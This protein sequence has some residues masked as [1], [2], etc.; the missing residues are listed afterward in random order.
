MVVFPDRT[1]AAGPDS[2]GRDRGPLEL[3]VVGALSRRSPTRA[4]GRARARADRRAG[5]DREPAARADAAVGAARSTPGA[6]ERSRAGSSRSF[7]CRSCGAGR[8]HVG[9]PLGP[10][11]V[12]RMLRGSRSP[13]ADAADARPMLAACRRRGARRVRARRRAAA[14]RRGD[15]RLGAA[16]HDLLALAHP[17]LGGPGIAARQ[18]P[19]A[20]AA[21]ELA[22][23]G[24]PTSA[25]EAVNRHSLLARLPEIVRVD[26]TVQFWLGQPDLRGRGRRPRGSWRCRRCGGCGSKRPA[27]AGCARSGSRPSAGAA[28]LALNV[29]SP[30]GEALDPLRLDPPL[31]WGRILPVLRF[32]TLARASPGGGRASASIARATRWRTRS[33]ASRRCTIRRSGSRASPRA[34]PSRCGSWRIWS[35]WTCC[36]GPPPRSRNR[37]VASVESRARAGARAGG[38]AHRGGSHPARALV[39]PAD[40]PDDGDLG[41]AFRRAARGAGDAG[42]DGRLPRCSGRG[43]DRRAGRGAARPRHAIPPAL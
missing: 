1:S 12:A 42:A 35:G 4:V 41:G 19:I 21:L 31:G 5:R 20:A 33:T 18:E 30:L 40:V 43:L 32:P 28:F 11:A 39:W 23:V 16:L 37:R 7:C 29:A 3:R 14:A 17:E 15:V 10:R 9:R 36:S 34:S 8:A 38:G 27:A 24:A 22:S 26:R 25:R 13:I 2:A 6:D